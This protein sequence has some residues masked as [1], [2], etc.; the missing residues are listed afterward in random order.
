[1]LNK[2]IILTIAIAVFSLSVLAQTDK[3]IKAIEAEVARINA[4]AAGYKQKTA[5]IDGAHLEN[6][7]GT[8]FSSG[9]RLVK[10]VATYEAEGVKATVHAYYK[11]GKV[12]YIRWDSNVEKTGGWVLETEKYYFVN[13][14]L[15]R[16]VDGADVMKRGD[17]NF[18]ESEREV[19]KA[20]GDIRDA[21]EN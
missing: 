6:A 19:M 12:I 9:K 13:G 5:T 21:F 4:A 20:D 11:G 1:M 7:N 18:I 10:A 16:I 15:V 14:R 2:A 3:Q 17:D 8:F